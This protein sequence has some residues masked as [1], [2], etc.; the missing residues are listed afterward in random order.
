MKHAAPNKRLAP[1]FIAGVT[2]GFL[3]SAYKFVFAKSNKVEHESSKTAES[4]GSSH[5]LDSKQDYLD[6]KEK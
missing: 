5:A 1:I 2:I 6:T 3:A 4:E